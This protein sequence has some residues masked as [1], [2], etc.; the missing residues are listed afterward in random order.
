[1]HYS[2]INILKSP[3]ALKKKTIS[4]L[5]R[6]FDYKINDITEFEIIPNMVK[7]LSESYFKGRN[8]ILAHSY[9]N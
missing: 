4:P 3:L 5:L 8:R 7:V 9:F 2:Q 1:M 6:T